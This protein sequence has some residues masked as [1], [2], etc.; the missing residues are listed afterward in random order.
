MSFS[1]KALVVALG[2][3]LSHG[4]VHA[5]GPVTFPPPGEGPAMPD[6]LIEQSD[7]ESG[8]LSLDEIRKAGGIVF[9]TPFNRFDGMGDGPVSGSAPPSSGVGFPFLGNRPTLQTENTTML[10]ISGLDAQTCLECHT[11]ISRATVPFTL[12]IGGHGGINNSP[13]PGNALFDATD[14]IDAADNI[15]NNV[16]GDGITNTSG[17]VINPPFNFG[18]GGV[19]LLGKEMTRDLQAIKAL[20]VAASAG[21]EFDLITKG[22]NFGTITSNGTSEPDIDIENDEGIDHDLVVRPFG[23]KGENF[24]IRDFDRGA[25]AFHMGIQANEL[26]VDTGFDPFDGDGDGNGVVE[27]LSIGEMSA[28][29]VFLATMPRPVA[30][31]PQGRAKRGEAIFNS[32]GCSTCHIPEMTTE[33]KFLTQSFP[34]IADD[35][36][37]NVFMSINISKKDTGDFEKVPGGGVIVPLFAGLK[38]H[39]MGSELAETYWWRNGSILYHGKALGYCRFSTVFT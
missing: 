25:M 20:A 17:R 39:N 22:V 23:R 10:R 26:F 9:T 38:R 16:T 3:V 27:E 28:L 11:T 21:T 12:G 35:P 19:E 8:A 7:I 32:I 24:T 31:K 33:S 36:D 34:D 5:A 1:R 6:N 37:A 18:G 14:A 2:M 29:G 30:E 15:N 4:I 13:M